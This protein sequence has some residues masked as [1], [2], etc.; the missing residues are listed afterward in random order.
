VSFGGTKSGKKS[1][2]KKKPEPA[3]APVATTAQ[4]TEANQDAAAASSTDEVLT[5]QC[6]CRR[7]FDLGSVLGRLADSTTSDRNRGCTRIY[8]GSAPR[9]VKTYILLV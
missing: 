3:S 7:A 5:R 8:P 2:A 1:A 9:R 6:P 4:A